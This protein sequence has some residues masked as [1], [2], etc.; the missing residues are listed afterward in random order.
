MHD[1][2]YA[3]TIRVPAAQF[4]V[5]EEGAV[6]PLP[7]LAV[8]PVGQGVHEDLPLDEYVAPVQIDRPYV[9][10]IDDILTF[11]NPAQA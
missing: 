2:S 1:V 11:E 3:L 6:F 4:I 10:V 9:V 8:Y 7:V 5:H